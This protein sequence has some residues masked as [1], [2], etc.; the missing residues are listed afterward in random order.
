MDEYAAAAAE[1]Y[2]DR[3]APDLSPLGPHLLAEFAR[4]QLDRREIEERWLRDLRQYR[5]KYDPEEEK[6][7]GP[8]RSRAYVRKTR[9][10]VKTVNSRVADLLFPAGSEKNWDIDT[11]PV[12]SLPE[13]QKKRIIQGLMAQAAEAYKQ[14]AAAVAQQG[15]DPSQVPPPQITAEQL[16]EAFREV[17]R[18]ASKKMSKVI[19]D[20]LVEAR[21]KDV[22]LRAIHSAHLYGTGVIKGPLVERKIRSSFVWEKD[23]WVEKTEY[24]HSPF[25]DHVPLWRFYPDMAATEIGVCRYAYELH[26]FVQADLADLSERK[27]FNGQ[28]IKDYIRSHPN[29]RVVNDY[30]TNELKL[31]GER[32]ATQGDENGRY[33]V[34]ERWGWLTGEQLKGAGLD[35]DESRC[36]ESFFSNVW[37]LPDGQVIKAVLQ[38]INGVT[39]PYHM[40]YFDKDETSI[41]GEGLASIIRDDQTMI[42]AATRMILDN[43]AITAGTMLEINTSLLSRHDDVNEVFPHKIY[44][45]NSSNPGQRAVVPIELPS[46]LNEL[47]GLVQMFENNADEVSA[48]PRYMAGE[49]VSNGAAGTAAGMSMLMGAVNI[50]IKDLIT[51]WDEGITRPFLTAM[52]RWNMQFN[53]D[54]SIK[55]DF[56]VKAR[57]T[58]SLVAKEVRARQLNEFAAMTANPMDAPFIKRD[59]LLRYRAEA[60]ELSDIVKTEDEV[61]QEQ[62]GGAMQMQQ[63]I[64]Q[65]QMQL[66]M[67]EMQAKVSK[68]TAEAERITAQVQLTLAQAEAAKAKALDSRVEAIYAALQAGGVAATNP[69]IAPA[70]DEILRSAGF[71]DATPDPAL[72]QL[73]GDQVQGE[74]KPGDA[75]PD[76]GNDGANQGM[77]AGIETAAVGD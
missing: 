61:A 70:G 31:I 59:K 45:R 2:A 6:A 42:N 68:L 13:D 55:G 54:P 49:N 77:G 36:H 67:A 73:M 48:V 29:G 69:T 74:F 7:I 37:L 40:Y 4:A 22:S 27:S 5:G 34:L 12:P 25:V 51:A 33:D 30:A 3:V 63:Q 24:Y 16:E 62:Q 41:F 14:Q 28:A 64:Q 75:Q 60:N 35:V 1:V 20:Q 32:T 38:P 65:Q 52:Y 43:A 56:D 46:K 11:T 23:R 39:W 10:K 26:Q 53:R 47:S 76:T 44:L 58:A 18:T 17:A 72:S 9:V 66:Q 19:E 21:Y 57:G 50:V 15:G 71:A 8:N